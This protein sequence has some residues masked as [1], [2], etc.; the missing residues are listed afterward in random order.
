MTISARSEKSEKKKDKNDS[1]S[2]NNFFYSLTIPSDAV[3]D[4]EIKHDERKITITF[5]KSEAKIQTKTH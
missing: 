3:G 4:P 5:K 1:R 2:V